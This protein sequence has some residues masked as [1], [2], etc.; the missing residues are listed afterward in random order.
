[1]QNY[2]KLSVRTGINSLI[3]NRWFKPL[4]HGNTCNEGIYIES[5]IICDCLMTSN[6]GCMCLLL[7]FGIGEGLENTCQKDE[8]RLPFYW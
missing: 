2:C 5:P 6:Q 4:K 3:L 1:M 7:F 8:N